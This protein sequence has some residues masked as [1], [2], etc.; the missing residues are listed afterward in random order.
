MN[1]RRDS[2]IPE[3]SLAGQIRRETIL[4]D[5]LAASTRRRSRRRRQQFTLAVTAVLLLTFSLSG[6]FYRNDDVV[7]VEHNHPTD[8]PQ[9]QPLPQP[10]IQPHVVSTR[11]TLIVEH[12]T[13]ERL[14]AQLDA[15]ELPYLQ[16][17]DGDV[18]LL[19]QG[20]DPWHVQSTTDVQAA[21]NTR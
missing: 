18:R 7:M 10:Q 19:G 11:P 12:L 17:V 2:T 16:T 3:L 13:D 6:L 4:V 20:A 9:P 21:A 5:V 1:D 15:A 8:P 14:L